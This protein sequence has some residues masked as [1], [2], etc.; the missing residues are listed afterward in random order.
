[1]S[2]SQL[3]PSAASVAAPQPRDALPSVHTP[4]E[5]S[6]S[7]MLGAMIVHVSGEIDLAQVRFLEAS[8]VRVIIRCQHD[9]AENRIGFAVVAPV[10]CRAVRMVFEIT[11]LVES[12]GVVGSLAEHLPRP[13]VK[14]EGCGRHPKRAK[15]GPHSVLGIRHG[16]AHTGIGRRVRLTGPGGHR[17]R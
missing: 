13:N 15:P 17:D 7:W 11:Q 8:G 5:A 14:L 2:I 9:L 3:D 12:L 16:V 4:F 1:M 6:F 10:E